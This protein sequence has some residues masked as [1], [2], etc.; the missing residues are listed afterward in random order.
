MWN[1][2]PAELLFCLRN[3]EDLRTLL[4]EERIVRKFSLKQLVDFF[5][6][7]FFL[8]THVLHEHCRCLIR[9]EI[10]HDLPGFTEIHASLV[11]L[12]AAETILN[13]EDSR[14]ESF[15]FFERAVDTS[16]IDL[17]MVVE[18]RIELLLLQQLLR[19]DDATTGLTSQLTHGFVLLLYNEEMYEKEMQKML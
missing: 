7:L 2:H 12:I 14:L 8:L 3:R 11:E 15:D 4:I 16:H 6:F 17:V 18:F 10:I 9:G 5:S 13:R 1:V 19:F